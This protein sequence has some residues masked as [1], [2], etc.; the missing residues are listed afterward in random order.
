MAVL[1][2]LCVY[3]IRTPAPA[4]PMDET[5]RQIG[6]DASTAVLAE[7][8]AEEKE[9]QQYQQETMTD[10]DKIAIPKHLL[11]ELVTMLKRYQT[12]YAEAPHAKKEWDRADAALK[13]YEAFLKQ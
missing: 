9:H 10:P 3:Y 7:M 13:R 5:A 6:R 8:D 4:D 11:T 12:R 1:I 2:A